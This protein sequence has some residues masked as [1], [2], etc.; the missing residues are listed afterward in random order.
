MSN[1]YICFVVS[2]IVQIDYR[3]QEEARFSE[4]FYWAKVTPDWAMTSG[5]RWAAFLYV[6]DDHI[7]L[8]N[9]ILF[10]AI[11]LVCLAHSFPLREVHR[12]P[13]QNF[14]SYINLY[15]VRH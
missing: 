13:V 10:Y 4:S 6:D 1:V 8:S 14:T 2:E 5:P 9:N 15:T 3:F 12:F 7:I 11:M